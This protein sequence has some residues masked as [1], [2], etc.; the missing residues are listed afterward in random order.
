M[1]R[2][3]QIIVCAW[4]HRAFRTERGHGDWKE[5]TC[6]KCEEIWMEQRA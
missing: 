1:R 3:L 5:V 4:S 2:L 6:T